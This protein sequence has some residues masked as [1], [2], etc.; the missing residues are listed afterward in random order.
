M[1]GFGK[2]VIQLAFDVHVLLPALVIVIVVSHMT[3]CGPKR[4]VGPQVHRAR[5]RKSSQLQVL[6][7]PPTSAAPSSPSPTSASETKYSR[8]AALTARH[9]P[10][11]AGHARYARTPHSARCCCARA[12]GEDLAEAFHYGVCCQSS[13]LDYS[14]QQPLKICS[15]HAVSCEFEEGVRNGN[16]S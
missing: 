12:R 1:D 13:M 9:S 16:A 7:H 6:H 8:A 5:E 2:I 4:P 14:H 11:A 15:F 3:S 10:P